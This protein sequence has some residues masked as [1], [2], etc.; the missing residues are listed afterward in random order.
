MTDTLS[1]AE[2]ALPTAV[3]A[4]QDGMWLPSIL[5]SCKWVKVQR[6][7]RLQLRAANGSPSAPTRSRIRRSAVV[8]KHPKDAHLAVYNHLVNLGMISHRLPPSKK[9]NAETRTEYHGRPKSEVTSWLCILAS[10]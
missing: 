4:Q 7:P 5:A 10:R 3:F 2:P 8:A 6:L 9:V 1:S